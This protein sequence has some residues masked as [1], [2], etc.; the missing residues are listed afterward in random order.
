M[1]ASPLALG[2]Y[3]SG[4][5]GS[6][7]ETRDAQELWLSVL[8]KDESLKIYRKSRGKRIAHELSLSLMENNYNFGTIGSVLG[9]ETLMSYRT[10]PGK[11]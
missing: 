6:F 7:M 8:G 3:R 10:I 11:D 1:I 4:A 5:T 2:N 9:N